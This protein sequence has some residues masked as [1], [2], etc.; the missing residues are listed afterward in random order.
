M[1]GER[2]EGK[3]QGSNSVNELFPG[4]TLPLDHH[5]PYFVTWCASKYGIELCEYE[6]YCSFRELMLL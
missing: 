2:F 5:P 6:A 3:T 4:V 1:G